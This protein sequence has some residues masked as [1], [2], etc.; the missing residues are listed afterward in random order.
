MMNRN[1]SEGSS[2]TRIAAYCLFVVGL[3]LPM[4]VSATMQTA[5]LR[6]IDGVEVQTTEVDVM[7]TLLE[8]DPI[9]RERSR[10][11]N[12]SLRERRAAESEAQD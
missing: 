9:E 4:V 11:P 1:Q 12:R 6:E 2:W 3:W 10:G 7:R 8:N 5:R